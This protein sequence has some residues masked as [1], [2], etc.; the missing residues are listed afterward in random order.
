MIPDKWKIARNG[1]HLTVVRPD[2]TVSEWYDRPTANGSGMY[3]LCMT[4]L[5]AQD[6]P[7]D[8]TSVSGERICGGCYAPKHRCVCG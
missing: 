6:P 4:L 8:F 7:G 3:A 2:G 5:D 1:K